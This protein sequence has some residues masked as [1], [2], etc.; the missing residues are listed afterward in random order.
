MSQYVGCIQFHIL[1]KVYLYHMFSVD[2]LIYIVYIGY[3]GGLIINAPKLKLTEPL[4]PQTKKIS[5]LTILS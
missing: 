1:N 3:Q 2:G 4:N 5:F